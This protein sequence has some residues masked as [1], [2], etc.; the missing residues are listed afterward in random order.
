MGEVTNAVPDKVSL[1]NYLGHQSSG[2]A[3]FG[4]MKLREKPGE[5][6]GPES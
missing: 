1:R 5:R 3:K 4:Y 2:D 6:E